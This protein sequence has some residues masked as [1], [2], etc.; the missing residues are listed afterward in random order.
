MKAIFF[1]FFG[2]LSPPVYSQ[3]IIGHIPQTEQAEH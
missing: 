1:D 3:F 2:V